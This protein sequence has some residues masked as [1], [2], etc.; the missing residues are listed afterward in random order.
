MDP[1]HAAELVTRKGK[2]FTFDAIEC[3]VNKRTEFQE[4]EIAIEL[5]CD[6]LNPGVWVEASKATFIIYPKIPSPMGANLSAFSDPGKLLELIAGDS[7][8]TL[9]WQQVQQ[10]LGRRPI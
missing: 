4:D 2:I 3:M 8:Q 6:Y 9:N 1:Q 5:V 7:V 10:K